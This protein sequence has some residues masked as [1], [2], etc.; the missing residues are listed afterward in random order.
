MGRDSCM[1]ISAL[2]LFL[3]ISW[4]GMA[5]QGVSGI[6]RG[7]E[8]IVFSELFGMFMTMPPVF[9]DIFLLQ[10]WRGDRKHLHPRSTQEHLWI[11]KDWL[12]CLNGKLYTR[13]TLVALALVVFWDNNFSA[14]NLQI[15]WVNL[16]PHRYSEFHPHVL[17][18]RLW[19]W[20]DI[21]I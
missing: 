21:F 18:M 14:W 12:R 19:L 9:Q 7:D 16:H 4:L 10:Q 15:W 8:L 3:K 2:H 6:V 17:P 1:K 20:F 13:A 11:G 5:I